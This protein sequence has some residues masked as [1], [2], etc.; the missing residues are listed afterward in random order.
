[1]MSRKKNES[2]SVLMPLMMSAGVIAAMMLLP[3]FPPDRSDRMRIRKAVRDLSYALQGVNSYAVEKRRLPDSLDEPALASGFIQPGPLGGRILDPFTP[4]ALHPYQLQKKKWSYSL[5]SAANPDT[6]SGNTKTVLRVQADVAPRLAARTRKRL[7]LIHRGL[8]RAV[9]TPDFKV[10]GDA[11]WAEEIRIR[12]GLGT[13][14]DRDGF[15]RPFLIKILNTGAVQI[16][17]PGPDGVPDTADDLT[18]PPVAL[19]DAGKEA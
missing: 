2:G 6:G 11:A 9:T 1:M 16:L 12:A 15:G 19:P 14:F 17:S 4:G 8:E 18:H 5:S 13:A 3:L 7:R 10:G